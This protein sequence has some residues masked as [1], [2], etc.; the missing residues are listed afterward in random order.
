MLDDRARSGCR[1]ERA[2]LLAVAR[3][4]QRLLGRALGDADAL[5]ADR[6]AGEVHH[7]E[8]AGEPA[9]LLAD[10]V[11]DRAALIPVHHGAGRGGVNAELVLDRM[12]AHVVMRAEAE[13]SSSTSTLGT[14]N[15]EMP[16]LPAGASGSRASTKWMMLSVR[17]CS[18]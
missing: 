7:R 10:Q 2:A 14:R 18:P 8:H 17:S 15:S 1:A 9:V 11:A 13:P 3:I 12:R 5:Q 6:E 4:L 16:L